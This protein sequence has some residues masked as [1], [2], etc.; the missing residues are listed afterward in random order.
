MRL[1]HDKQLFMEK[2]H[3][4]HTVP[5]TCIVVVREVRET[6]AG[7]EP[8]AVTLDASER[9]ARLYPLHTRGAYGRYEHWNQHDYG[10]F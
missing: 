8:K 4:G 7:I 6:A 3:N 1:L 10:I 9:A 2:I 5:K